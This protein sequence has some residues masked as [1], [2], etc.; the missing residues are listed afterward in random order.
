MSDQ[1][2]TL[3]RDCNAYDAR[4]EAAD[5]WDRAVHAAAVGLD[6]SAYRKLDE[7]MDELRVVIRALH[8]GPC[9]DHLIRCISKYHP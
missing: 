9:R 7:L 1:T 5:R 3:S 2:D 6:N 4:E 8:P